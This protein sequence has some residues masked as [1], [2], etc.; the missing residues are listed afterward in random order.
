[1]T[2]ADRL[3]ALTLDRFRVERNLLR[4]NMQQRLAIKPSTSKMSS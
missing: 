2:K 4:E 3:E 1:M